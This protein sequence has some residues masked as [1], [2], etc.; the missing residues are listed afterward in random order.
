MFFFDKIIKTYSLERSKYICR[1][2]NARKPLD[3]KLF[4]RINRP[5]ESFIIEKASEYEGKITLLH[6]KEQPRAL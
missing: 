3:F 1:Y 4:L 2:T 5:K 6:T